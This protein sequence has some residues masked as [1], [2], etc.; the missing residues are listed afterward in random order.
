MKQAK[1]QIQPKALHEA[2]VI[3]LYPGDTPD[4][5]KLS[6]LPYLHGKLVVTSE[7]QME[8]I[9]M[10]EI[11]YCKASSNYTEIHML[12]GEKRLISKTLKWTENKL[13]NDAYFCRC[14]QSYLVNL[15]YLTTLDKS[16]SWHLQV[17]GGVS[18]PVSRS[19]RKQFIE[20]V[21]L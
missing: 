18:V 3:T 17:K 10:S 13:Q 21:H 20:K 7:H 12:N 16:G 14:H 1:Y 2:K 19:G 11:L 5:G 9:D 6:I 8:W 4:E 15:R